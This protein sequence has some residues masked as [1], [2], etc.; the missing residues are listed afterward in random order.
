MAFVHEKQ[1]W[2]KRC[3]IKCSTWYNDIKILDNYTAWKLFIPVE[4]SDLEIKRSDIFKNFTD[5]EI[6]E[7]KELL[8]R[9]EKW[10]G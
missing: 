10:L 4:V 6:K 7:A 8:E 9:W 1:V 3:F 5:L 2:G